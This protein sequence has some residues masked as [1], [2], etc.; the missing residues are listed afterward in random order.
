M[1]NKYILKRTILISIII[2]VIDQITK[3][4]S[5]KFCSDS[6]FEIIKNVFYFT[7]T[8][9]IGIA[10]SLN[11]DN[12]K[13]IFIS[14]IIIVF[15]IRYLFSNKKFLNNITLTSLDFVLAGGISNLIDRIFRGG[16]IDFIKILDFPIF[17]IA[18]ISVVCGWIFFAF[19]IIKFEVSKK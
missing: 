6:D 19:Y 18:D 13:N 17:N 15:I 2:I 14:G 5:I 11:Q 12:L 10:F 4:L 16:V 3:L 9:N 7:K 1:E 8:E